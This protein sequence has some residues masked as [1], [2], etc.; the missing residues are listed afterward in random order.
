MASEDGKAR[1]DKQV[2]FLTQSR[3]NPTSLSILNRRYRQKSESLSME[4]PNLATEWT[5]HA[6]TLQR[7]QWQKISVLSH[8]IASSADH[9]DWENLLSLADQ[10]QS[11]V[12]QFFKVPVCLP[13]FRDIT[14]E[15]EQ[16]QI[17][18]KQVLLLVHQALERN[19]AR[20]SSLLETK[21]SIKTEITGNQDNH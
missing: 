5:D 14:V 7:T 3:A 8:E 10:R 21:D 2:N 15:L 9:L 16:I 20:A 11:L 17:Q 1:Y 18:H 13:L 6:L 12:E 19:D 4:T